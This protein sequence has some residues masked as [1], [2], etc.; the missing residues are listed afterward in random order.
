[1]SLCSIMLMTHNLYNLLYGRTCNKKTSFD[2]EHN[3][4][5]TMTQ[6]IKTVVQGFH[7]PKDNKSCICESQKVP[8]LFNLENGHIV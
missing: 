8:I 6:T 7:H 3:V 4:I 5:Y 1:M 2:L